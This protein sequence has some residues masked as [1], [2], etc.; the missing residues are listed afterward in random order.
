MFNRI[1]SLLLV[2]VVLLS[3]ANRSSAA[4]PDTTECVV[5]LHG[6][7]RSSLS[8]QPLARYLENRGFRVVNIGY[9][10]TRHPVEWLTEYL[11]EQIRRYPE[12][13]GARLHF[14]THSLGGIVL[15]SFL[16]MNRPA[17][18]GRVV[19]LGPPS[20]GSELVD[21]LGGTFIFGL[22]Y[23]PA[24]RQLGTGPGSVPNCLEPV[25]FELGVI[26]GSRS[27]NPFFS[28]MIPGADDGKVSVERARAEGMADFL[29]VPRSHS[30]MMNSSEVA[31]QTEYF[32]RHGS[33]RH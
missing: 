18:L 3:G 30:F 6:L 20:R 11:G 9:P 13:Q 24:G 31:G 21:R 19:M 27:L 14:V 25:G 15:R 10:S 7:G 23:G 16:A 4:G 1:S 17:N 26:A 32:L 29:I 33:F 12:T 22:I 2:T 5:L 8:M 28:L